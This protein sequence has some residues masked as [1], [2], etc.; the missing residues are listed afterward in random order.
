MTAQNRTV[1]KAWFENGDTPTEEQ[2]GDLID[3]FP[4]IAEHDLKA[5]KDSPEFTGTPIVPTPS[6]GDSSAKAANTAWVQGEL[7]ADSI[8][9]PDD[10]GF[11]HTDSSG[12]TPLT[13]IKTAAEAAHVDLATIAQEWAE[14]HDGQAI[15]DATDLGGLELLLSDLRVKATS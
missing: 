8:P 14:S 5:P 12:E 13:E 3:S 4:T 7:D 11:W 10:T 1:L 9:E 2:F 6:S 15:K